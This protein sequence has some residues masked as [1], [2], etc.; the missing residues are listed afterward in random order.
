MSAVPLEEY[1]ELAFGEKAQSSIAHKIQLAEYKPPARPHIAPS[2]WSL[3]LTSDAT[4]QRL[5]RLGFTNNARAIHRLVRTEFPFSDTDKHSERYEA[6]C[7]ALASEATCALILH[8]VFKMA[9]KNPFLGLADV[10]SHDAF[11]IFI[12]ALVAAGG[13]H[14]YLR[15]SAWLEPLYRPLANAALQ[16]VKSSTRIA[17]PEGRWKKRNRVSTGT[18]V[19]GADITNTVPATNPE[20][21]HRGIFPPFLINSRSQAMPAGTKKENRR[22]SRPSSV[23]KGKQ[24]GARQT[25]PRLQQDPHLATSRGPEAMRI[26]F[27]L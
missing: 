26:Q 25:F 21:V 17:K 3:I 15:V 19:P 14:G 12:G 8:K 23:A 10:A 20:P 1:E 4:R 5:R 27:L 18:A 6:V 9:P 7:T 24:T 11:L 16:A 22:H 13:K 2:Q